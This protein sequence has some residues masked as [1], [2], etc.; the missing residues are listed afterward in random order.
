ML[1]ELRV[2]TSVGRWEC[3]RTLA[4]AGVGTYPNGG[5]CKWTQ[6]ENSDRGAAAAWLEVDAIGKRA[7]AQLPHAIGVRFTHGA[8]GGTSSYG[9]SETRP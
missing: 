3:S 5:G 1:I 6:P 4:R 9:K 8:I 7:W 2:E